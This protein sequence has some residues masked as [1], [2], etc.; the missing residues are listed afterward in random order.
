MLRLKPK[1]EFERP[2]RIPLSVRKEQQAIEAPLAMAGLQESPPNSVG[3][4]DRL[5]RA[6]LHELAKSEEK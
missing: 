4:D 5:M 2:P 6:R 1:T 3:E